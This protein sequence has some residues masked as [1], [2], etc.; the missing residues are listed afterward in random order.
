M[1]LTSIDTWHHVFLDTTVIIDFICSPDRINNNP[2]H[3]QR[4]INT[5]DLFKYFSNK[6]EL[7]KNNQQI[8]FYISA[9]TISE[10]RK[11]Q[12][13]DELIDDLIMLLNCGNVTFVDYTKETAQFLQKNYTN[14]LPGNQLK[15]IITELEKELATLGAATAR[16]WIQDDLKIAASAKMLKKLDVLLTGDQKTFLTL[17]L[18]MDLNVHYTKELPRNMFDDLDTSVQF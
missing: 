13:N 3:R 17:A 5:H 7:D 15:E 8:W 1:Q 4:V 6:D 2:S 16:K 10:L 14:Y 18:A 12:T 11:H 9:I